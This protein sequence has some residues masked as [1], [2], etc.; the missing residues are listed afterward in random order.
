MATVND[1]SNNQ[2]G[3]EK[4]ALEQNSPFQSVAANHPLSTNPNVPNVQAQQ[5]EGN[6][7]TSNSA[8]PDTLGGLV[9]PH[10]AALADGT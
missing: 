8:A 1:T 4:E 3:D 2:F 6:E 7:E 5:S 9:D 10:L